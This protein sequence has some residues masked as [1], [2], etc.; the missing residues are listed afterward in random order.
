MTTA[1]TPYEKLSRRALGCMY[2]STILWSLIIWGVLFCVNA[3]WL[4]PKEIWIGEV[5]S[6]IL[7]V[8]VLINCIINPYFRYRRYGYYIDDERIETIEGYLFIEKNV[9]PVERLHKFQIEKG[10]ITRLF[11]VINITVTTAGGDLEIHLLEEGKAEKIAGNLRRRINQIA[12]EE[13]HG[14]EV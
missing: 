8:I 9:V 5:F 10:P 1:K 11:G 12:V 13:K 7:A 14:N 4:S 6:G 2:V 3:F